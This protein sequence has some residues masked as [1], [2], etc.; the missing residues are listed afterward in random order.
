MENLYD[1]YTNDIGCIYVCYD[2]ISYVFDNI[3]KSFYRVE[4]TSR[5]IFVWFIECKVGDSRNKIEILYR[6]NGHCVD[7]YDIDNKL[8][9]YDSAYRIDFYFDDNKVSKIVIGIGI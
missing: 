1:I 3:D 2:G 4:I 9:V 5:K 6:N 8:I 7:D